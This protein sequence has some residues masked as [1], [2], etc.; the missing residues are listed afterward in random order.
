MKLVK[1][2]IGKEI[3]FGGQ[4]HEGWLPP[5]ASLPKATSV[6]KTKIDIRIIEEG[7]YILEWQSQSGSKV[8]DTWHESV[9]EAEKQAKNQ[10]GAEGWEGEDNKE[11]A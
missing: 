8:G 3:Q 2:I 7:G 11:N 4:E 6:E 10:F 9:E 1:Q 5:N